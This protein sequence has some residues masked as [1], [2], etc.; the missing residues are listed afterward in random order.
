MRRM[1]LVPSTQKV[2]AGLTLLELVV[3]LVIL[4]A[5]A[6]MVMPR[7]SGVVSQSN[8]A[9]NASVVDD[10]NRA[11]GMFEARYGKQTSG[12]DSLL[13]TADAYFTKLHP[14]LLTTDVTRPN[15]Q[16]LA[17]DAGQAQSLKDAGIS[18]FHDA[19]EARTA[20]PS[21]NSTTFRAFA[22]GKKVTALVKTPVTS[23]HGSTFIDKA[24]N[25]NQF[26][27]D[28][29]GK[30]VLTDYEY[31]VCGLGGPTSIKGATMNEIPLVQS[32][33][34][35]QYYARVLCVFKIPHAGATGTDL[36]PAQ[37][38]GSFLPDGTTLRS[39]VESFNTANN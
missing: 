12:W 5:L 30:S 21:D 28:A 37:Y 27:K 20:P 8:S 16:I 24:F 3:V 15:L 19:D 13:T 7:L 34:P 17:L 31:V 11:V 9:T 26:R 25:I 18:G 14:N 6:A 2:R 32:A 23:G 36:I 39:N 1:Y 33:N 10:V 35:S 4:V 29:K 38:V 22:S